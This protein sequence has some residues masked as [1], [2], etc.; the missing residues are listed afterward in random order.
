MKKLFLF[1]FLLV[2]VGSLQAQEIKWMS[3]NEALEAQKKNPKKI[4]VDAYTTWCGPCKMLDKNTFSNKDLAAYVN[5][6][7]YAVKF[8]AE[9]EEV[10]NFNDKVFKNPNYD[11]KRK[12]RNAVHQFALAMGV[13]A[14]PTMV[15]FDEN[16]KFL[17]PVKGYLTPQKLE[18]FLKIFATDDYKKVKTDEEWKKY[19]EEFKGTFSS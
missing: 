18:I 3:M 1:T 12:G 11:P 9:G 16:A 8:N 7:Y 2:A 4:F 14:Y 15:F 13:N 5:K 10:V 6:H 19:Q 17:T